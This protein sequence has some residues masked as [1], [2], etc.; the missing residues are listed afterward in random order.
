VIA[1]AAAARNETAG[2]SPRQ[3]RQRLG[4]KPTRAALIA[5]QDPSRGGGASASATSYDAL[6]ASGVVREHFTETDVADFRRRLEES[7][8]VLHDVLRRPGFGVGDMTIGAELEVSIVDGEGRPLGCNDAVI[9]TVG[10]PRATVELERFNLEWNLPWWR[11]AGR[12]FSRLRAELEGALLTLAE[13]ARAHGGRIVAV[14]IL[15]TLTVADLDASSI[16]AAAR[17]RALDAALAAQRRGPFRISIH[18]QDDFLWETDHVSF[19]GANTSFQLHL[20]IAPDRFASVYNAAQLATAPVIAAA[21]NAPTF[22]GH[23]LWEETR[24]A[25][26]KQ[27]VDV[28]DAGA[29]ERHDDSRV[30][31]GRRWLRDSAVEQFAESVAL[32]E[33]LLPVHFD[34]VSPNG[35]PQLPELRLHQGT[36]W[37]WNRAVYDPTED[38][39]LR[40]ELRMLPAGPT[41]VDMAANAALAIGLT[42]GLAREPTLV[43]EHPF[44]LAERSFYAAARE[45]LTATVDW[46]GGARSA[47]ELVLE[48]LVCARDGL[49]DEAGVAADE[50]DD[51]LTLIEARVASGQ[52]GARWQ[53]AALAALETQLDRESALRA[54]LERY[55]RHVESGD[56]VHTW[57]VPSR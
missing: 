56:P 52:T 37:R 42:L 3:R 55:L 20:R 30:S 54:M 36:V 41:P 8:I 25:L 39:H 43:A 32:H 46:P 10:D 1:G 27:S 22:L 19:E 24:I 9:S 34:D 21:G 23:R 47:R 33:P 57:P 16:T 28:R 51:L 18:G 5:R 2:L 49:V 17:Y 11:L 31:F 45:G 40:L 29:R 6:V 35:L 53:R 14:G 15:P 48:L 50:A 26:F 4:G 44:E 13:A 7:L 38:G 12:S